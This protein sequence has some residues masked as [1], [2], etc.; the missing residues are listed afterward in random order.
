[1]VKHYL[2]ISKVINRTSLAIGL[3]YSC[4]VHCAWLRATAPYIIKAKISCNR[5]YIKARDI[6]DSSC[7]SD[8]TTLGTLLF[9]LQCLPV[10]CA[11]VPEIQEDSTL[12]ARSGHVPSKRTVHFTRQRRLVPY[13]IS[14]HSCNITAA[15]E[16]KKQCRPIQ[17][18]RQ[19]RLKYYK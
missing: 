4:T 17:M 3:Y 9:K 8:T 18:I 6:I 1:M 7:T 10:I 14:L 11:K 19:F 15:R 13:T 2:A 5:L 16:Y 12:A